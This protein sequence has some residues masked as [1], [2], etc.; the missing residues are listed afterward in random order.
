MTKFVV[1]NWDNSGKY[2]ANTTSLIEAITVFDNAKAEGIS[3]ELAQKTKGNRQI[4]SVTD[5]EI[6]TARE[7]M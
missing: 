6:Q 3:V 4:E 2:I 5:K 1:I 7:R